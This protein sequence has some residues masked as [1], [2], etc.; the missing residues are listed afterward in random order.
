MR[1]FSAYISLLSILWIS[2]ASLGFSTTVDF[3]FYSE[4]ISLPLYSGLGQNLPQKDQISENTLERYYQMLSATDCAQLNADLADLQKKWKLNDY[5]SYQILHSYSLQVAPRKSEIHAL[6]IEWALLRQAGF[7]PL[8]VSSQKGNLQL[9]IESTTELSEGCKLLWK[10]TT[11]FRL[12]MTGKASPNAEILSPIVAEGKAFSY[13]ISEIPSLPNARYRKKTVKFKHAG[14]T[15]HISYRSNQSWVRI[16]HNYPALENF[17][18]VNVPIDPHTLQDVSAQLNAH[19]QELNNAQKTE[20]LLSFIR[21]GFTYKKDQEL[22]NV[23]ERPFTAE[24]MLFFGIGDC[25]DKS[26]LFFQLQKEVIGLPMIVMDL[27]QHL[28][29]ATALPAMGYHGVSFQGKEYY[30]TEPTNSGNHLK[31]GELPH[32]TRKE[33]SMAGVVGSWRP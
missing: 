1:K 33:I 26:A 5:L 19:I 14:L 12:A 28:T 4:K 21:L 11:Y 24:E 31:L 18:Y 9:F 25:E 15:H 20:F 8:L 32:F 13:Q 22:W 16:M 2:A 17:D 3:S 10:G 30:F 7:R 27:P 29:V 23:E 6:V